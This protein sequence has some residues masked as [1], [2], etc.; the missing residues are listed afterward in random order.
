MQGM[1]WNMQDIYAILCDEIAGIVKSQVCHFTSY[2]HLCLPTDGV[3]ELALRQLPALL[4]P[5]TY[6]VGRGRGVKVVR[7]T[8]QECSL[9]FINHKPVSPQAHL[10]GKL[11]SFYQHI[12]AQHAHMHI[13]VCFTILLGTG[14]KYSLTVLA[15]LKAYN[16]LV[17][18][19]AS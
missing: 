16:S 14:I 11:Y 3:G 12:W 1:R 6:K 13:Q 9:A 8:I 5:T 17:T 18:I 10:K 2:W 19:K 15:V 4:P 7:H